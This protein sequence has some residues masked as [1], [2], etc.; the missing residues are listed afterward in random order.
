MG[1]LT[2]G[3]GLLYA[4]CMGEVVNSESLSPTLNA[5]MVTLTYSMMAGP[6]VKR[7]FCCKGNP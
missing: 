1:E 4:V 2:R 6:L 7:L 5:P 3:E